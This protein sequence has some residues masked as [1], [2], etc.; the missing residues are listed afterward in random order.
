VVGAL[1]VIGGTGAWISGNVLRSGE[2]ARDGG[3]GSAFARAE[4]LA[5]PGAPAAG[6]PAQVAVSTRTPPATPVSTAP[7]GSAAAAP[8]EGARPGGAAADPPAPRAGGR[9]AAQLDR[10]LPELNFDGMALT[11]VID[12]LRDVTGANIVVNWKALEAQGIKRD[13]PVTAR[14]K[15]VR[16]DQALEAILASAG[17]AKK[18]GY[19]V[20]RGIITISMADDAGGTLVRSSY[21]VVQVIGVRRGGEAQDVA[22]DPSAGRANVLVKMITGSVAPTTW[23]QNGGA[24]EVV[25][26]GGE[27]VA[28]TTAENQKAIE[29][30]LEQVRALMAAPA[31]PAPTPAPTKPDVGQ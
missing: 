26:Q 8:G 31:A 1:C 27:L 13:E 24:G 29:N 6:S 17:G 16:F 10:S 2:T 28:T 14:L 22:R 30:L 15:N 21:N 23:K 11:D 20:D 19:K 25:V 4:S 9:Q 12:L 3:G 7:G 5:R 18:L